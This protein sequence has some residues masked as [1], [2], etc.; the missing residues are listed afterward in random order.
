MTA[1]KKHWTA[2]STQDFLYRIASDFVEQ[3]ESRLESKNFSQDYLAQKLKLS[4]GRI[5]QILNNPGN[6][7]LNMIIRSAR[8]LGLKV[9]I[10][11]YDDDDSDNERG[12]IDSEIFRMCWENSGKPSDFWELRSRKSEFLYSN[13]KSAGRAEIPQFFRFATVPLL[14]SDIVAATVKAANVHGLPLTS[15]FNITA[16][17]E[18]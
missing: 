6:F 15:H 7:T 4:K 9:A 3:L 2:T 5:S 16:R 18:P 14:G 11:A 1:K 17:E 8:A 13:T 10:V 12:P